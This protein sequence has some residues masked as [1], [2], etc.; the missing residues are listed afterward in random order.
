MTVDTPLEPTTAPRATTAGPALVDG[1]S[2]AIVALA[3]VQPFASFLQANATALLHPV[4]VIAYAVAWVVLT[5][6]AF[7]LVRLLTRGTD[8]LVVAGAFVAFNLSFWNFGRWLPYEP[9]SPVMRWVGIGLWA[10]VTVLAIVLVM[11]LM[12][13]GSARSFLVIFLSIWIVAALGGFVLDR[14][15]L[16][17]TD[18][19]TT[20]AGP[21][22]APFTQHPNVYWFVLDE[23]ARGDQTKAWTGRDTSWFDDALADRGFSVSTSSLA[24][25]PFTHLSIPSTFEMEYAFTP[26]HDYAG[27]YENTEQVLGGDNT[28]VETFEANGY[29]FVSAPDGSVEWSGC[30]P[31]EARACIEP[32]SGPGARR[33]PGN[34][35][36]QLTPIGSF[37]LPLVHNDQAS[38]LEGIRALPDDGRPRFVFAHI[39]SPH[40]PQRYNADCT[41]R[42]EWISGH[43]YSAAERAEAY[44]DDV[45]CVDHQFVDTVDQIVADDPDAVIIVQSDHGSRLTLDWSRSFEQWSDANLLERLGALN[46]IRLPADC[47]DRD[48]EGQPLANTFR[49]V[50]ACLNGT[51]PDLLPS[52]SFFIELGKPSSLVEVPPERLAAP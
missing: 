2:V 52:R 26:G 49:I 46:A 32:V 1:W 9:A 31:D 34:Q 50:F 37:E 25:Y 21:A 44:A 51:E 17:G 28:V 12:A 16:A 7:L 22:I 48:I 47:A 3:G 35:L 30:P 24:A 13:W 27:G 11:K 45:E 6:V 36:V 20:Y 23:H 33:E 8:A 42:A 29:Q 18:A 15:Q 19:P 41:L 14:Q 5:L 10:L 4:T 38:V 40:L 43:N 39:L